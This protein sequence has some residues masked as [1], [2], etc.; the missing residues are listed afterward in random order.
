VFDVE[1]KPS[2]RGFRQTAKL[3]D[4]LVGD[5][6]PTI[7]SSSATRLDRCHRSSPGTGRRAAAEVEVLARRAISTSTFA[8]TLPFAERSGD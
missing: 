3:A 1:D 5:Q 6:E 4:V 2:A 7:A 8:S